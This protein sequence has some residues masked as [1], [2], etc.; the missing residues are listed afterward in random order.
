ML[1]SMASAGDN[2]INYIP[3]IISTQRSLRKLVVL[4]LLPVVLSSP[5]ILTAP[6]VTTGFAL[7]RYSSNDQGSAEGV[8]PPDG[9]GDQRCYSAWV[10]RLSASQEYAMKGCEGTT[11]LYDANKRMQFLYTNVYETIQT[12][13]P[14]I[15]H[16]ECD[17]IPRFKITGN[18]TA[19]QTN[20]ITLTLTD[21][22]TAE[23][24]ALQRLESCPKFKHV[25]FTDTQGPKCVLSR[26]DCDKLWSLYIDSTENSIKIGTPFEACPQTW[27]T[28]KLDLGEEILLLHWETPSNSSLVCSS[29]STGVTPF[30]RNES[31]NITSGVTITTTALTF[32]GQDLYLRSMDAKW[33]SM[34]NSNTYWTQNVTYSNPIIGPSV[35]LGNWTFISPTI[36]IAHHPVTAVVSRDDDWKLM[37]GPPKIGA[38]RV[39]TTVIRKAGVIALDPQ[40]VFLKRPLRRNLDVTDDPMLDYVKKVAQGNFEPFSPDGV[41]KGARYETVPFDFGYLRGMVPASAYYDARREDCW[42]KQTHCGTISEDNYRPQLAI[43][44]RIWESMLPDD[45]DCIA[46]MLVDP[47]IALRPIVSDIAPAE[48]P[49][50]VPVIPTPTARDHPVDI[51]GIMFGGYGSR[52]S[53]SNPSAR[54]VNIAVAPTVF[55]TA[56]S[57][58]P[59]QQEAI[60][61]D[62]NLVE[63]PN[64]LPEPTQRADV[65]N[66]NA[67]S[68]P[69]FIF[70]RPKFLE[71]L[72]P[73][74]N[75]VPSDIQG[76]ESSIEDGDS[77][78]EQIGLYQEWFDQG[79]GGREYGN[80]P[81]PHGGN[82]LGV[83][84]SGGNQPGGN[85][86]GSMLSTRFGAVPGYKTQ[87]DTSNI[88]TSTSA[89]SSEDIVPTQTYKMNDA[90]D[91]GRASGIG[92]D[93]A[94]PKKGTA[95]RHSL[96][97]LGPYFVSLL[98]AVLGWVN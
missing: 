20:T 4:C 61:S 69:L 11:R 44:Q 39:T 24:Y 92:S 52:F 48:L 86:A 56:G 98:V 76:Q 43:P 19:T 72:F 90:E 7:Y 18:I 40:D 22:T 33:R 89:G 3:M 30:Y 42:G 84:Q 68:R 81:N 94:S 27:R 63:A 29:S 97:R 59:Q 53:T 91:P 23:D 50:D 66:T 65:G 64:V 5:Q 47:P 13:G 49:L 2:Y 58:A 82:Q 75:L 9:A 34:A 31:V 55:A 41:Q 78:S 74:L 57:E 95:I 26:R 83:H 10:D 16:T 45:F 37:S 12:L 8:L 46:P 38:V 79:Y 51:L 71:N 32:R 67:G 1:L 93:S 14:G 35:F 80:T 25:N 62:S 36:Y 21:Y 87:N 88:A 6:P 54:P 96:R 60:F 15:V 70:K 28:C 77:G 85:Q 73:F 17:G